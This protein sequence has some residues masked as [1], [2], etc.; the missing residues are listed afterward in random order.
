MKTSI[1]IPVYNRLDFTQ[2]CLE[3]IFQ[4]GSK[5]DFEIIVVDNAS[6]DGT[7][8]FLE[9]LKEK[10]V[11]IN[12]K[13]NLGFAKACNLGAKKAQGEYLLFLN[14]DTIVTKNWMDI[15][16]SELDE[17]PEIAI[18]GS[19]LLYPDETIQHAGVVFAEDKTPYHIYSREIKEKHYVNKK[20]KFKAITAAC[21]LVRKDIFN[22]IGGFDENFRN[23]Y[24]DIDLCLRIKELGKDVIYCPESMVY[25]YESI[26]EGRNESYDENRKL[27]LKKWSDK[28]Q[29][30]DYMYM[31]EDGT[32]N[33]YLR[34]KNQAHEIDRLRNELAFIKESKFWKLR[35]SYLKTKLMITSPKKLLKKKLSKPL[36]LV[37]SSFR[38]FKDEGIKTASIRLWN[39]ILYG[40]GTLD[41]ESI[42]KKEHYEKLSKVLKNFKKN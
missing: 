35:D 37:D 42:T 10:I 29:Q 32:Q 7:K 15:L 19:K 30:D 25:H 26:S 23:G 21:M 5:Y 38:S 24:E 11:F 18:A 13:E 17:N 33:Q 41:P 16:I 34:L 1:I 20:R 22:E 12:N 31:E 14:N 28:V 40:K 8:E 27:F 39:F 9:N 3:S 2:K 36:Y 4:F 6:T